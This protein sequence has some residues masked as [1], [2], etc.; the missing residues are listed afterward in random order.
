M[1][2]PRN[3]IGEITPSRTATR[4]EIPVSRNGT[5]KSMTSARSGVIW[6][7]EIATSEVQ[8]PGVIWSAE[9]ATFKVQTHLE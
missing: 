1:E 6:S 3:A 2:L 7:A 4:I 9:I 8:T 5:E